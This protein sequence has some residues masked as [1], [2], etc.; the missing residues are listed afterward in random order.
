MPIALVAHTARLSTDNNN[1]TTVAINTTGANFLAVVVADDQAVATTLTD[2]KA[3]TW[4][5][6]TTFQEDQSQV[7]LYY[8]TNPTVGSGHTFTATSTLSYP[9]LAVLAFSGVAT[10]SPFDVEK[11]SQAYAYTTFQNTGN[12]TPT[13][14]NEVLVGGISQDAAGVTGISAS[15]PFTTADALV[16]TANAYGVA[17][18]YEIQTTATTRDLTWTFTGNPSSCA[19]VQAAFKALAGPATKA[20]PPRR[21]RWRIIRR[22]A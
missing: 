6:L 2:S 19:I 7:Q 12:M 15:A 10:T 5:G 11:G 18:A 16:T 21:P 13:A 1:V 4:T 22:A 20:P 14:A 8:A 3:N 17:S 9:G